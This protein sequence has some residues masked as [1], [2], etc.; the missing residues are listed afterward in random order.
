MMFYIF[1]F[2]DIN[3]ETDNHSA[4]QFQGTIDGGS[5]FNVND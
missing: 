2:I 1:K 4:F 3:P 5:N